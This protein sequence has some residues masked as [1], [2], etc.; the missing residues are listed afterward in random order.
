MARLSIRDFEVHWILHGILDFQVDFWISFEFLLFVN[1]KIQLK[2]PHEQSMN[3]ILL[4]PDPHR[5]QC[6]RHFTGMQGILR[7]YILNSEIMSLGKMTF[8]PD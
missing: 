8:V 4:S 7:A 1:L 6:H 3:H 5:I 2:Y